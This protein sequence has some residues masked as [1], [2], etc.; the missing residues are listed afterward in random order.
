LQTTGPARR[1][2]CEFRGRRSLHLAI[3]FHQQAV[4]RRRR[5]YSYNRPAQVKTVAVIPIKTA[6]QC[7][8][9]LSSVLDARSRKQLVRFMLDRVV[10][11][12]AGAPLVEATYI[13]TGDVSMV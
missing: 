5:R 10:R 11:A 12:V 2:D 9:R 13:V 1:F 6:S 7:K 3:D 4:Q 8:Q